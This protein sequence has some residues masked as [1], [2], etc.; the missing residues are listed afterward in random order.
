MGSLPVLVAAATLRR[1]YSGGGIHCGRSTAV[2]PPSSSLQLPSPSSPA[3]SW[4]SGT[5]SAV[6][7]FRP[8]TSALCAGCREGLQSSSG[9]LLQKGLVKKALE[10]SVFCEAFVP[11]I[12]FFTNGKLWDFH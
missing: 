4:V 9:S 10:L 11:L 2:M 5:A 8:V 12:V 1:S 3:A 6:N 7:S